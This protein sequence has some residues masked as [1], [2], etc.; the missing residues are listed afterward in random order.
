MKKEFIVEGMHCV[1]CA[2][3]VKTNLLS[4]PEVKRAKVNFAKKTATIHTSEAI[5]N[6]AL[7]EAVSKAGYQAVLEEENEG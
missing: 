1:R 6:Q 3:R 4:I 2:E 5:S 7:A